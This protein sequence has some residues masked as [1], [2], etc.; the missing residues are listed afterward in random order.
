MNIC[1]RTR[2]QVVTLTT[3]GLGDYSLKWYGSF[4]AL[5]V[6]SFTAFSILGLAVFQE[7]LSALVVAT[8]DLG[9]ALGCPC[10]APAIEAAPD[11][12]W[13]GEDASRSPS[14]AAPARPQSRS[15][16]APP[17][18]RRVRWSSAAGGE[19]SLGAMSIRARVTRAAT[20]SPR[21]QRKPRDIGRA[22]QSA[23]KQEDMTSQ[24]A[25]SVSFECSDHGDDESALYAPHG[26]VAAPDELEPSV[27]VAADAL[28][29]PVSVAAD[30]L[31]PPV[32]SRT[33]W[34]ARA[35]SDKKGEWV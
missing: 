12:A 18:A 15:K 9:A 33:S 1:V 29:P 3:V 10:G 27:S 20:T 28:E 23:F 6:L 14:T 16:L 4:G 17:T 8:K 31:E 11:A 13:A 26:G 24:S 32:R 7:I 5:E 34:L 30:A 19:V 2:V 25:K 35:R 22:P 21:E